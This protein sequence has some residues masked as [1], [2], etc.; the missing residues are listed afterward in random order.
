V[1]CWDLLAAVLAKT[2]GREAADFGHPSYRPPR[3][4]LTLA[5]AAGLADLKP[6]R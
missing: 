6:R 1:P 4:A 3:A 2:T 5:Q